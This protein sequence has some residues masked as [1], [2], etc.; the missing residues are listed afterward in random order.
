MIDAMDLLYSRYERAI[1][2]L[3][4]LEEEMRC[5]KQT[6]QTLRETGDMASLSHVRMNA[7]MIARSIEITQR[8]IEHCEHNIS[9]QFF[10]YRPVRAGT[11]DESGRFSY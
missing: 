10:D 9:N 4:H 11:D 7:D 2:S 6:M 8:D 1:T 5:T 3:R